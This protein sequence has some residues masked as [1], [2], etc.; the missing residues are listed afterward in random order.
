MAWILVFVVFALLIIIREMVSWGQAAFDV[1]AVVCW[2]L[3]F[4]ADTLWP[5]WRSYRNRHFLA[6]DEVSSLNL[7]MES[8]LLWQDRNLGA[9]GWDALASFINEHAN[10]ADVA[11]NRF[12]IHGLFFL[13][14]CILKRNDI[15]NLRGRQILHN[16]DG[17]LDI[18]LCGFVILT[19]MKYLHR[20]GD[21]T[22]DLDT[23]ALFLV[24]FREIDV[25]R[26][27]M[28]DTLR[29]LAQTNNFYSLTPAEQA[30]AG[31]QLRNVYRIVMSR[32]EKEVLTNFRKS[33]Q[34]ENFLSSLRSDRI[35]P[36]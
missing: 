19:W 26:T 5:V 20:R 2:L 3:P 17:A 22:W 23:D 6:K 15:V 30:A 9:P 33:I 13:K 25:V 8:M 18:E 11:D 16:I 1:F 12:L 34:F 31:E 36:V 7:D 4:S 14:E 32:M 21:Y 24:D 10:V 27:Q 28:E 29:T 35:K